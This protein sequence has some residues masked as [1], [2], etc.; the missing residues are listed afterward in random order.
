[1]DH[2]GR[3]CGRSDVIIPFRPCTAAGQNSR[4][5]GGISP[6]PTSSCSRFADERSAGVVAF[7]SSESDSERASSSASRARI[8]RGLI[9]LITSAVHLSIIATHLAPITEPQRRP[10]DDHLREEKALPSSD[11]VGFSREFV[12]QDRQ[13]EM[14]LRGLLHVR[15]RLHVPQDVSSCRDDAGEPRVAATYELSP[16]TIFLAA[17]QPLVVHTA[18][19]DFLFRVLRPLPRYRY[20]GETSRLVVNLKNR[21]HFRGHSRRF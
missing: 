8:T 9:K 6:H 15:G 17:G 16:T 20:I 14:V 7:Q 2:D 12:L 10:K 5:S 1:M 21:H 11:H 13:D 4:G 18:H 19:V 3:C